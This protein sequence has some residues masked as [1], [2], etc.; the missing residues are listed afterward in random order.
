M[1]NKD[2]RETIDSSIVDSAITQGQTYQKWNGY[3]LKLSGF[4]RLGFLYWHTTASE[5]YIT[6]YTMCV[7]ITTFN[8]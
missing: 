6:M 5:V 7:Y 4:E 2:S 8:T 3:F 1:Y